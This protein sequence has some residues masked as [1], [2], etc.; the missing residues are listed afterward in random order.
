MKNS[1]LLLTLILLIPTLLVACSQ[2]TVLSAD[3]IDATLV[4]ADTGKPLA[5]VPVV[6]Y[7]A[8]KSGSLTGDSLPCGAASVEEAVTDK[9]GKFHIP[10]WGPIKGPCGYMPSWSPEIFAFKSG[11][12]PLIFLNTPRA[13][14]PSESRSV[15][16][17]N[18]KT[19]K[20]WKD[21]D[22]DLRKVGA[23]SYGARFGYFN[24][25]LEMI[26]VDIDGDCN[27]KKIPNMLRALSAQERMFNAAG[28]PL[29]SIASELVAVDKSM[30]KAAPWCGS[31]KA[32]VEGLGP[33]K[34]NGY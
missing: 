34:S 23:D 16:D 25:H 32:F 31:P 2:D 6:A 20:M 8:L 17:W 27:W 33:L 5:G 19:I 1:I 13:N 28:N 11:Y 24:G 12:S 18:G 10:G 9:N 4:D 26:I 14:P 22:P 3:P 7:W 15:S 30:Q 29:G 21:P